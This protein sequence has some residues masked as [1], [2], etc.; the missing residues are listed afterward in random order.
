MVPTGNYSA[1]DYLKK[2]YHIMMGHLEACNKSAVILD[3]IQA[4]AVYNKRNA[5]KKSCFSWKRLYIRKSCRV[6]VF[7]TFPNSCAT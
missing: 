5:N 2:F 4:I 3:E 7:W 1:L 6:Q